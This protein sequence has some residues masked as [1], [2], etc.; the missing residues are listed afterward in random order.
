LLLEGLW[1]NWGFYF[2][3][4][5]KP[6]N[7]GS[8]DFGQVLEDIKLLTPL[9]EENRV[10]AQAENRK[11]ASRHFLLLLYIRMFVFR[12]YLECASTMPGGITEEYKGQ[13]LL[14]QVA[15]ETL[16]VVPDVF[17]GLV[18]KLRGA[19]R[20]LLDFL[21]V[22]EHESIWNLLGPQHIF[23][24]LDEAQVP[25][26]TFVDCFQSDTE[27]ATAQPI[28]HQVIHVWASRLPDL[29]VSGTRVSMQEVQTVLGSAVAKEGGLKS[30]TMTDLG[31]FDNKEDQQAYLE[32]YLPPGF[33]DTVSG[34][35][36]A[37]RAG[38]WLHGRCVCNTRF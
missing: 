13:W 38:Y 17:L 20:D 10:T 11:F 3:A 7:I 34:K 33:L 32:R 35:A 1:R 2:T 28:L 18:Q 29:I 14:L 27:P 8:S 15:P 12:I 5:N 6:D 4:R 36:M 16:L 30:E 31:A 24:V 9:T 26:N 25:A 19:S 22:M 21:I 23:C 37:S